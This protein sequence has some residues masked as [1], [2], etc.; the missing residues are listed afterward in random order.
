[1][2]VVVDLDMLW[3][4]EPE[5]VSVS[6]LLDSKL[7]VQLMFESKAAVGMMS[8]M[9]ASAMVVQLG[10]VHGRCS[11]RVAAQ[12]HYEDALTVECN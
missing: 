6:R 10:M 7:V 4:F 8:G 11:L 3:D 1:M 12:L 5:P 9:S 2:E